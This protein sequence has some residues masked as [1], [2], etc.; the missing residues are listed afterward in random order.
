MSCQRTS[1]PIVASNDIQRGEQRALARV[2]RA[3]D[4]HHP[5]RR[6]LDGRRSKRPKLAEFKIPQVQVAPLISSLSLAPP[7]ETG[8]LSRFAEAFAHITGLHWRPGGYSHSIVPGGL[9]VTS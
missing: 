1:D 8:L 5:G 3:G 2:V 7:L 9:E 4:H 6:E